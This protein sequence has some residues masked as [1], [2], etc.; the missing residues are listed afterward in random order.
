MMRGVAGT[1]LQR[2][3][4]DESEEL[5]GVIEIVLAEIGGVE[6]RLCDFNLIKTMPG[7]QS[8]GLRDTR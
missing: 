2:R 5:T 1:S 8:T 6:W 7:L 3:L 4:R